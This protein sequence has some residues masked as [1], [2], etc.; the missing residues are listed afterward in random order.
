MLV[1]KSGGLSSQVTGEGGVVSS[2]R[3]WCVCV[4][5]WVGEWCGPGEDGSGAE[6]WT[7]RLSIRDPARSWEEAER[8]C[9]L[10]YFVRDADSQ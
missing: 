3:S 5:G 8:D 10:L 1:R 7:L 2:R 4:G 6:R 9:P